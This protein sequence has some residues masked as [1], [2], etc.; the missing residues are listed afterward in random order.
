MVNKEAEEKGKEYNIQA[1]EE[2]RRGRKRG[3]LT[4]LA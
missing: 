2:K 3:V 1:R 4:F